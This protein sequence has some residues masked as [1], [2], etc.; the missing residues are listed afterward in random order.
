MLLYLLQFCNHD[1]YTSAPGCPWYFSVTWRFLDTMGQGRTSTG[2]P[3]AF[4]HDW[5]T[6]Y[7]VLSSLLQPF[8]L[9]LRRRHH[10]RITSR[11]STCAGTLSAP[12]E[13]SYASL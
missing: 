3:P 11:L 2:H 9:S 6:T 7:T 12:Q 1:L 4:H 13:P 5:T 10:R 8:Q